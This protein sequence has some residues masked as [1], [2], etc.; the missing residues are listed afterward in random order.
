MPL[1]ATVCCNQNDELA[2]GLFS[3]LE[4]LCVEC[5][6]Q[7]LHADEVLEFEVT[8]CGPTLTELL[9]EALETEAD[10]LAC[11]K[12]AVLNLSSHVFRQERLIAISKKG[13]HEENSERDIPRVLRPFDQC[14]KDSWKT[15]SVLGDH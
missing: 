11:Q 15:R 2:N 7:G 8:H 13:K 5:L 4:G 6:L 3:D 10:P 14:S 1:D 9:D 12:V